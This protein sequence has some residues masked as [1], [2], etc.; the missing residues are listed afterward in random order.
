MFNNGDAVEHPSHGC[1]EVHHARDDGTCWVLFVGETLY[2]QIRQEG[3]KS[4]PD[5]RKLN[6][7]SRWARPPVGVH[8]PYRQRPDKPLNEWESP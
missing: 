4:R 6:D 3:L 5:L 2:R 8:K 7:G 1:G